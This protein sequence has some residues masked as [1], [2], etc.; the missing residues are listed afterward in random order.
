[1]RICSAHH[2]RFDVVDTLGDSGSEHFASVVGNEHIVLDPDA[3]QTAEIVELVV[4]DEAPV[5][6]F[7]LPAF[8]EGG[9]EVDPRFD[10][11]DEAR[12]QLAGSA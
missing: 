11:E 4:T 2:R 12:L 3:A 10:R 6:P 5:Q 8:D 1:M 9:D 7:S